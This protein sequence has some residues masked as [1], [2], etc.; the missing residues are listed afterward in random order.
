MARDF[1]K[2]FMQKTAVLTVTVSMVLVFGP[3]ELATAKPPSTQVTG[4]GVNKPPIPWDDGCSTVEVTGGD[5][6]KPP[7]PWDDG[8]G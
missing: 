6:N 7:I 8:C 5:V 4:G 3:V 2:Q 1:L